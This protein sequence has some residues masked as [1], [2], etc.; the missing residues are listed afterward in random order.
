ML[1]SVGS[2]SDR[3]NTGG[4]VVFEFM[5]ITHFCLIYLRI[6]T[7]MMWCNLMMLFRCVNMIYYELW[8]IMKC[9]LV[10]AWHMTDVVYFIYE[11]WRPCACYSDLII[12]FRGGLEGCYNSGIRA[13][14]SVRPIVESVK[15]HDSWILSVFYPLVRDM[16]VNHCRYLVVCCR[17]WIETSGGEASL[18]GYVSVV[19]RLIR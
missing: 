7:S 10:N 14:R 8:V 12:N 6:N 9:F 2:C 11:L 18:L 3:C 15:L 1:F 13:G 17:C 5:I 4:N 16:W 19:R